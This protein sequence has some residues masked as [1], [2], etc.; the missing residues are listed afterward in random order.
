[1]T[2]QIP[3]QPTYTNYGV[4]VDFAGA[5]NDNPLYR[6]RQPDNDDEGDNS[7]VGSAVNLG[8]LGLGV[9]SDLGVAIDQVSGSAAAA[10]SD[11]YH[12][13]NQQPQTIR[14]YSP[15]YKDAMYDELWPPQENADR[16]SEYYYKGR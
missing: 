6:G 3:S 4:A 16:E 1:M 8:V 15:N 12:E 11:L 5:T 14:P 10:P 7:G 2:T 13:S 9:A